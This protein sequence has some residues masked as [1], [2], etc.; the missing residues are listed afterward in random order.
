M[1]TIARHTINKLIILWTILLLWTPCITKQSLK[2]YLGIPVAA[3][4]TADRPD[5]LRNCPESRQAGDGQV[6]IEFVKKLIKDQHLNDAY[7]FITTY[8][9]SAT[10]QSVFLSLDRRAYPVPIYILHDQ[11][12]I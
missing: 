9:G 1:P 4:T 7:A 10:V 11:L 6:S 3:W 5:K 2:D 12:L 8:K